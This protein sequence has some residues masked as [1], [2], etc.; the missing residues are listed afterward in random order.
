MRLW[1]SPGGK[2]KPGWWH[3]TSSRVISNIFSLWNQFSIACKVCVV[4][5]GRVVAWLSSKTPAE[6]WINL[7]KYIWQF[8]QIHFAIRHCQKWITHLITM[9]KLNMINYH[10]DDSRPKVL[11]LADCQFWWIK[12]QGRR[13]WKAFQGKCQHISVSD[14]K[15]SK[16]RKGF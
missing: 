13:A 7:F 9:P 8:G 2:L 4:T 12:V 5:L 1:K 10:A 15:L 3:E 11:K 14:L 6:C 16:S